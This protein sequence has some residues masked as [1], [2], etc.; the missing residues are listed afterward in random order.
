MYTENITTAELSASNSIHFG[1]CSALKPLH[2]DRMFS[3][4]AATRR[5]EARRRK[6]GGRQVR[7]RVVKRRVSPT[8]GPSDAKIVVCLGRSAAPAVL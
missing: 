4:E 6:K 3:A 8:S 7:G 2:S 1:L 5:R